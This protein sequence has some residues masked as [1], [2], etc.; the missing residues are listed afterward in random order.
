MTETRRAVVVG[1]G[2]GGLAAAVGLAARGWQV[3]VVETG[4]RAGGKAGI[5]VLDGVEVDTGP[6]VLTLPDAFAAVFAR[7]GMRLEDEIVLRTPSPAFRYLYPDGLTLDVHPELDAT[8]TAVR[9]ALG[10]RAADELGRFLARARRTW[11]AAAPHFILAPP[12]SLGSLV[13]PGALAALPHLDAFRTMRG[14]IDADVRDPHLRHLLWRYATYNG[15][16]VRRA[17]ATLNCIAHV[18]LGLGGFG[19]EGGMR[20][21]VDA[22]VRACARVGVRF[23]FQRPARAITLSPGGHVTGVETDAGHLPAQVVI[24]NA[25]ASSVRAHLLP[26]GTRHGISPPRAASTSGWTA[27]LR[28]GR[29]ADLPRVA[30]TVVFPE[31]YLAEFEDLFDRAQPPADPTVYL[32]AQEACHGRAGWTDAEP[33]FVMANAPAHH[34]G[35]C[36]ELRDRVETRLDAAGLRAPADAWVWERTPAGLAAEHP[37]S[38]GALYGAAS[39]DTFAAFRRPPNRIAGVPGLYLASG[40]AH[41]GGGMPLCARSG[42]AAADAAL[43]DRGASA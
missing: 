24:A 39:N 34:D 41:P 1:A 30:H 17:P 8:L 5:V 10:P 13:R 7:A 20:A 11:E 25:D 21:L 40:S 15:S 6:S 12:P 37:G 38:G 42:L 18:E 43:A 28:A 31:N 22:C 19:V 32:C 4:A 33:V 35:D 14:A 3:D 2:F 26:G 36:T 29:H 27:I 16:D 23:H 9:G